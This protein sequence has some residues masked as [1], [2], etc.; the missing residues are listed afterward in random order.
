MHVGIV[1]AGISGLYTGLLLSREGHKVTIF[2]AADRVGGRIYT[3]RFTPQVKSQDVYF[4]AGAMRIPRSSLHSKVFDLIRYLNTHGSVESRIEL[5]PYVLDHENNKSFFQGQKGLLQDPRWSVKAGL[6]P[7]YCNKTPQQLLGS[8]VIPWLTLLRQN[9]DEGFRKLLEYDEYSFRA[10]LRSV[11]GWPHEVIEFVELF[12]SQTNQYDLSFTEII[13]QNLDFDTK[14]CAAGLV[15]FENIRLNTRVDRITNLKDGRV[16]LSAKGL[17]QTTTTAFDAVVLAIPPAA[18]HCIVDRPRWSFMKEQAIRGAHYEPLYKMGMHFRSRFWERIDRN[19]C[20]GGQS[21]TDLRFRW[22]VFPSNDMG[23]NGSGVLLLYSWM[24]DAAKWSGLSQDERIKICL[25]DLSQYY[26]DEPEIDVYEQY[27]EAFDV[28]WTSEWCG[29]DAMFLPGQFSRFHD[30]AKA[31]EG[32][33][34]FVGEHLS[35]HHTWIAGA[36]DSAWRTTAELLGR[37][38]KGETGEDATTGQ[39]I[40]ALGREYFSA[41]QKRLGTLTSIMSGQSNGQMTTETVALDQDETPLNFSSARRWTC[42]IIVVMMT[43]TIAFCSSIHTAAIAAIAQDLECSDTVATLGVTTFL[44]GFGTGPLI[45][46][47]LSEIYGRN[48]VYRSVLLLF[49]LFNIGCALSPNIG[50]LLVFRFLCGFFGSPTVTNSGG[51]LTDLWPLSH[52]SVPLALFTAAS[53]LGPVIAPIVG[54]FL[55]EHASWRWDFWLV[56]ILSGI[57][58]ITMVLFLPETY[59]PRLLQVKARKLGIQEPHQ[60]LTQMLWT[61]ITRPSV[62]FLTEPILFL[63]SLYMAFIYGILYLDFTA[64]PYV[65]QKT[66][67]WDTGI[68]G[69]SFLGIGAGMAIATAAS[70]YIN[71]VYGTYVKKLG[72]PKPEARLPHL[73]ILSWLVPIGLFWF[74]WTA[75]PSIHWA[76]C[77][78]SGIPF[79]IGFVVLSLGITSYLIDCYGKYAASALAANAILRSLFGAGFPLFSRQMYDKLGAAWATSILGFISVALAPLPLLF[80]HFGPR[81]RA[82]STFHQ[83]AIEEEYEVPATIN[84]SAKEG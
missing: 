40:A 11:V 38:V 48:P 18:I 31:P 45:F 55:T 33:I 28:M 24:S 54:G 13:M 43:A 53:F 17:H 81:I 82:H 2:E 76:S 41:D 19:P 57:I 58:Y 30:V 26:A 68:A 23:S 51:S 83:R 67:H 84:Q 21:T 10:Y 5:I 15:G 20:F 44:L 63:L 62:M 6:P 79:G 71:R 35:T 3:H 32:Q 47:P 22:I 14:D 75:D 56:S 39:G 50:A 12:C 49:V 7:G 78:I 64:Y 46:A 34:F 80:Y 65:F 61:N 9:F 69:L 74:A 1:G 52:R 37:P 16:E 25:H 4:E 42:T 36:I 73:I 70:P 72:G 59:A 60:K 29:G 66:R 27:I 77:I 8:V